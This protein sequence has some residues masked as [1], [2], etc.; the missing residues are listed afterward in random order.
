M[1]DDGR[2]RTQYNHFMILFSMNKLCVVHLINP[3]VMITDLEPATL[4]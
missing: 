3:T 2:G 4:E 1:V